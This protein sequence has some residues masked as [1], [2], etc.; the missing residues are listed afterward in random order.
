M[1][2]I[3][4]RGMMVSVSAMWRLAFVWVIGCSSV[5]LN[6]SALVASTASI[7]CDWGQTRRIAAHGWRDSTGP[8]IETN[9][10]LGVMPGVHAVDLYFV[11]AVAINAVAWLLAPP[12]YR[13]AAPIIA[14]VV[15]VNTIAS[16][17]QK[18]DQAGICGL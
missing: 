1:D 10:I 16:N 15:E 6:R 2:A 13:S 4:P 11:G 14:T 9:P 3:A 17:T 7:A 18:S 12:R 8:V 5:S